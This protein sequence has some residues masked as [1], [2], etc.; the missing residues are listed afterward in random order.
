MNRSRSFPYKGESHKLLSNLVKSPRDILATERVANTFERPLRLPGPNWSK[1]KTR[2]CHFH[3]DYRHETNKCRELKHQIEG[4]IKTGQ[5]THLVKG[6]TKKREKTFDT[7]SG[8]KK[9]EEKP[10]LEKTLYPYCKRK[11]P[12]AEEETYER[13]RDG[14]NYVSPIPNEGSSDPVVIKVYIS[15]RQVNMAYLD[16]E[17]SCEVIYEHC[18]LKLKPSIRSLRVDSNTPLVGFLGEESWLLGEV[19]LEVIIGEEHNSQRLMEE[20]GNSTNNGQEGHRET[21]TNKDKNA[22]ARSPKSARKC[23]RKDYSPHN[24]SAENINYQRRNL[25]HRTSTE[26]VQS[27]RTGKTKEEKLGPRKKLSCPRSSRRIGRSRSFA[28]S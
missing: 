11:R 8:E 16:S 18:F 14:R 27:H 7:Q 1:D 4:A 3:E 6:V 21:I 15:G 2:Y 24:R 17:S 25:Q 10:V 22:A 26:C 28:R 19:P 20:E 9:K 5:L 12:Q 13:Q 23:F